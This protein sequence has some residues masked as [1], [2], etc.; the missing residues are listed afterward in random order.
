ML[1]FATGRCDPDPLDELMN[2]SPT[3][4]TIDVGETDDAWLR[5]D[6]AKKKIEFVS[7]QTGLVVARCDVD[8][9]ATQY[10]VSERQLGAARDALHFSH[11]RGSR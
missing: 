9:S 5:V 3:P 6:R 7:K 4:R 1:T 2:P 8:S 11:W 10:G